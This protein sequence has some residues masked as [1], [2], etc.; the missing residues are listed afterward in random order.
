LKHRSRK[1]ETT[2]V[3][4]KFIMKEAEES[5]QREEIQS[6]AIQRVRQRI[7]WGPRHPF[8]EEI[9]QLALQRATDLLQDKKEGED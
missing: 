2:E 1:E 7:H 8:E 5:G 3:R 6:T 4:S 9:Y